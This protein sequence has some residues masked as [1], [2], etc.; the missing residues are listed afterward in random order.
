MDVHARSA[1]LSFVTKG[2]RVC[3]SLINDIFAAAGSAMNATVIPE[4]LSA[5]NC[6]RASECGTKSSLAS[7]AHC[8]GIRARRQRRIKPDDTATRLRRRKIKRRLIRAEMDR[9]IN[10]DPMPRYSC[11]ASRLRARDRVTGMLFR[12]RGSVTVDHRECIANISKSVKALFA[13]KN[14][15]R[16]PNFERG[17]ATV[18]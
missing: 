4:Q 18:S 3:G 7:F 1:G 2:H 17:S 5:P 8:E 10:V 13:T 6:N 15:D 12:I 16:E 9:K 14:P 11:A